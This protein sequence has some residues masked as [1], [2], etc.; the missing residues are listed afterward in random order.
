M[1]RHWEK[2]EKYK[3][4]M[5]DMMRKLRTGVKTSEETKRKIAASLKGKKYKPMSEE[6]KKNIAAAMTGKKRSPYKKEVK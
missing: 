3:K 5:S 6:G 1:K 2:D 4:L